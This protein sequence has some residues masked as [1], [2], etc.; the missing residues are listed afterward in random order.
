MKLLLCFGSHFIGLDD[1]ISLLSSKMRV[2][3][4]FCTL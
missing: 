2:E 3:I 4:R 1:C